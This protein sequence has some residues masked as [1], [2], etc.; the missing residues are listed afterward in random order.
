H[1][2][3]SSTPVRATHSAHRRT[4][5]SQVLPLIF[6]R[7]IIFSIFA[8]FSVYWGVAL[9]LGWTPIYLVTVLHLKLTDPLYIAGVSLPW[10]LQGLV[11]MACGAL[12]DRAFQLTGSVRRSH[13]FPV[14][15]LPILR[16][17]FPHLAVSLPYR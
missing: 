15:A 5:W 12:A 7:N 11:L 3:D 10:L 6:S 16:A 8:A 2:A 17:M 1:M 4:R 9:L 14:A 13:V